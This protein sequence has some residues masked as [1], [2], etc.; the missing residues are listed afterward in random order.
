MFFFVGT[1]D[2]ET[3]E[4][5]EVVRVELK[6][7]LECEYGISVLVV[8]LVHLA[9]QY[10]SLCVVL[11]LR[12]N[13]LLQAENSLLYLTH[14]D[15]FLRLRQQLTL[16]PKRIVLLKLYHLIVYHLCILPIVT[17][18]PKLLLKHRLLETLLISHH[19]LS[20]RTFL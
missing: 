16:V 6:G 11:T 4:C 9:Q 12:L 2:S 1:G 10:P 15:Q 14:F 7:F 19:L 3:H 17:Q 20:L 5:L 13:F 8:F 18:L